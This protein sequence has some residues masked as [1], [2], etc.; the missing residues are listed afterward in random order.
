ML[1]SVKEAKVSFKD[2][3]NDVWTKNESSKKSM[4][5]VCS[6]YEGSIQKV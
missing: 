5:V 2:S 3:T 4:K 6:E 1:L